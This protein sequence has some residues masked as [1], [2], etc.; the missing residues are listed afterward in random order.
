MGHVH[1]KSNSYALT[2]VTDQIICMSMSGVCLECRLRIQPIVSFCGKVDHCEVCLKK[3]SRRMKKRKAAKDVTDITPPVKV[4]KLN[5]ELDSLP[6]SESLE[7]LLYDGAPEK[8]HLLLKMQ[9]ENSRP[10]LEKHQRKWDPEF[11]SF[12]LSIYVRSPRVYSDLRNSGML[13]LPS[14]SLLRMYKNCVKQKPGLCDDNLIW[15]EREAERQNVSAFG[16]HGGLVIDEMSIQDDLQKVR[17]GMR[18]VLLEVW[19]WEKR[20]I[21]CQ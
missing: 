13:V 17:K 14:E 8:L 21:Y 2:R 19:I 15:M 7:K 20:T 4:V 1:T 9:L 12:C 6:D 18:G 5:E 10:G 3:M 16:K 11:I